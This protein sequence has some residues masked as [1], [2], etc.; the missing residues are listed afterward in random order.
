MGTPRLLTYTSE[1]TDCCEGLYQRRES[2][3][4]GRSRLPTCPYVPVRH[5][6]TCSW[7]PQ[8]HMMSRVGIMLH[9]FRVSFL[10]FAT[11]PSF[12]TMLCRIVAC[13]PWTDSALLLQI[14]G[15]N[16]VAQG[17]SCL[18]VGFATEPESE[19]AG[20][21]GSHSTQ[22]RLIPPSLVSWK[23]QVA[24]RVSKMNTHVFFPTCRWPNDNPQVGSGGG[25]SG[26]C[27]GVISRFRFAWPTSG[28]ELQCFDR[29][30]ASSVIV[31]RV[32]ALLWLSVEWL[33]WLFR[34]GLWYYL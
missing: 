34:L 2:Q 9:T 33:S 10:C 23:G 31:C 12:P 3:R 26:E 8:T 30:I 17:Y 24:R 15:R 13:D 32:S 29:D 11:N 19:R 20:H 27:L 1:P 5:A 7:S 18:S 14:V 28:R 6:G 21:S 4:Q 16:L 22:P 25:G